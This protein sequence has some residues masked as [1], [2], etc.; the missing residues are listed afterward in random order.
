MPGPMRIVDV[1]WSFGTRPWVNYGK[2]NVI[3]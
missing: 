3:Q 2:P 1:Q